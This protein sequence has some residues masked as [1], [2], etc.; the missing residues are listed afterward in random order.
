MS[1]KIK[2]LM[3][4]RSTPIAI[5]E[6]N[7]IDYVS[8][9]SLA[10]CS[11]LRPEAIERVANRGQ[12]IELF[13]TKRIAIPQSGVGLDFLPSSDQSYIK[14]DRLFILFSRVGACAMQ[15]KGKNG[16]HGDTS[17]DL[18]EEVGKAIDD[19]RLSKAQQ[20]PPEDDVLKHLVNLSKMHKTPVLAGIFA[21]KLN[22]KY[23]L[24]IPTE[25][26]RTFGNKSSVC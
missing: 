10:K 3:T 9:S 12:N 14:L 20:T 15:V 23:G 1:T 6:H 13:G 26:R 4:I 24:E 16:T 5:I 8:L 25:S 22:D 2:S 7:G 18:H 19:Y 21:R 17:I 11:N